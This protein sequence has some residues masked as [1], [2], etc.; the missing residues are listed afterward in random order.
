MNKA[1]LLVV[2]DDIHLLSGIRD[3]LELDHYT[4]MT[5]QNG[6]QALDVLQ[7]VNGTPP[8]LIVSD[9]MMPHMD[10]LDLLQAVRKN[11]RWVAIPFIF[12]T[13]KGEKSDIQRG[14]KL[15]VDDYLVKP[16]DA[17]DLL[18]A[19][20]SRLRRQQSINKIQAGAI[21]DLKRNI[22]TIL[23]H[24]FRTPLTL[25][26]AYADMLKTFGTEDMSEDE[27]LLFLRGV[28][29]GADRL[30]RLIENFIML[31]ELETGDARKNFA[32]RKHPI[33]DLSSIVVTARD[34]I[35]QQDEVTHTCV[36]EIGDDLP[37]IL[38]DHDFLMMIVR[39]LIDNAV[40]FSPPEKPVCIKL[41]KGD[42]TLILEVID[43]GRGIHDSEY[44]YIWRSFYQINRERFEDQ[45]SGAGLAIV[46][47]LVELHDGT[48]SIESKVDEG[49]TFT[50]TLPA[51]TP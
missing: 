19:V 5:A 13:A 48:V 6:K 27:L 26:V 46:K 25:V 35:F 14:K 28:N 23:N 30:R 7:T 33:S 15:G 45:G 20:E 4:V 47:G 34:Q 43:A 9:I 8:D 18:V 16:F 50:V 42:H 11:E 38:G 17:D 31:V 36:T 39:E 22:L 21:S 12:L 32:Y 49:S 2:E 37:V 41:H 10:G 29:S 51:Y 24:E 1:T 44:D 3:I 40:K